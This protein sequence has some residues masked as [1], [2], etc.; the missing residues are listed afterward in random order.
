M[1]DLVIERAVGRF[2]MVR[3][4]KDA[5]LPAWFQ[6]ASGF[7]AMV[8]TPDELSLM[9]READLGADLTRVEADWVGWFV[10]GP[11]A[12]E[13]VGVMARLSG[14]LAAAGVSLLAISTFDTDWLFVKAASKVAAERAWQANGCRVV[15]AGEIA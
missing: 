4:S 5:P 15:D 6:S 14:V 1:A 2:V 9:V 12:F 10:R 3:L 11:L 8:R 13:M 7:S